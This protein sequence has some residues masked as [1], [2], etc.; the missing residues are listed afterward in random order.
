MFSERAIS[1]AHL[2]RLPEEWQEGP[3]CGF[4]AMSIA[5]LILKA[6]GRIGWAAPPRDRSAL[7]KH[8]RGLASLDYVARYYRLYP[9]GG[10]ID[11]SMIPAV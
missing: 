9:G 8:S 7:P 2:L 3:Y 5:M 11:M 4:Y 10:P 1:F 6:S